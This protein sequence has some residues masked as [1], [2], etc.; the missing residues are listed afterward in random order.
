MHTLVPTLHPYQEN[1]FY[2]ENFKQK[3]FIQLEYF[4]ETKFSNS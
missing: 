3:T 2:L 1:F 4:S